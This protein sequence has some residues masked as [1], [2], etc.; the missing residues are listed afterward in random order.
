MAVP[1]LI[2][3]LRDGNLCTTAAEALGNIG[4]DAKN[5]VPALMKLLANED[6]RMR[7]Y[8][9]DALKKIDPEAARSRPELGRLRLEGPSG[10]ARERHLG[11]Q[12]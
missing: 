7:A 6:E 1:A 9:I 11:S 5:A 12:F 4:P 2:E 10:A 8:S 3:S